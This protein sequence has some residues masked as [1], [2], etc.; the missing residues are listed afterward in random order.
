MKWMRAIV[1]GLFAELLVIFL[2]TPVALAVGLD[3]LADP[4]NSPLPMSV[5]I[6][7]ASFVAPLFS[8]Q[9]VARRLTGRFV[10]HG[11]LVGA[12]AFLVYMIPMTIRGEHQPVIYWIA[13]AMKIAGGLTGGLVAARRHAGNP[14][15]MGV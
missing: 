8:T 13:H 14:I 9:W 1:G 10:A 11:L 12:A 7:I 6:V 5:G 2:M 4:G 15:M 3:R